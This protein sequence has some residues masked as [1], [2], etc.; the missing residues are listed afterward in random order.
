MQGKKVFEKDF[1]SA[2]ESTISL[3]NFAIG[4]YIV[5]TNTGLVVGKLMDGKK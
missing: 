2:T 5:K 3:S 1:K 4:N